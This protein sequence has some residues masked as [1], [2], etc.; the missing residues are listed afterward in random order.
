MS[1]QIDRNFAIPIPH[2]NKNQPCIDESYEYQIY[3][4]D[5]PSLINSLCVGQ[6][7]VNMSLHFVLL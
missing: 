6:F 5:Y 3:A 7:I 1:L 4:A 2:P